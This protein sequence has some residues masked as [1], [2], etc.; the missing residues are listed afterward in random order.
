MVA[1]AEGKLRAAPGLI[2]SKTRKLIVQA[3]ADRRERR[4]RV[5]GEW[6][7]REGEESDRV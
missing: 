7:C 6:E 2:Q 1:A 4:G 5:I 3:G